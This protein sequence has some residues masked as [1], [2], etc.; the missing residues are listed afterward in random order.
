MPFHGYLIHQ[1]LSPKANRCNDEY[2]GS[3]ENR[4]RFATAV[5]ECV[6][7]NWPGNKPLFLRLSVEDGAGWGPAE[8]VALAKIAKSVKGMVPSTYDSGIDATR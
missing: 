3:D 2:G 4:M 8:S 1:F 5:I 6:R 7:A